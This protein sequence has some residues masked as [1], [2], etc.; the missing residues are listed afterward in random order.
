MTVNVR[1][2]EPTMDGAM[3]RFGRLQLLDIRASWPDEARRFAAKDDKI[4]HLDLE[5][6]H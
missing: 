3:P 5:D 6:C 4:W 1:E 2:I